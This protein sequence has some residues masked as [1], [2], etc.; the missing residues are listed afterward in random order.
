MAIVW[1]FCPRYR[2]VRLPRF[3]D[4]TLPNLSTSW[5]ARRHLDFLVVLIRRPN[6]PDRITAITWQIMI[7]CCSNWLM[8]KHARCD[9]DLASMKLALAAKRTLTS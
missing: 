3:T 5:E 1:F 9:G 4:W 2:N 8:G 7:E 6:A